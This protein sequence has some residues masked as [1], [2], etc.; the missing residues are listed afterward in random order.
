VG[1]Q[2]GIAPKPTRLHA[3]HSPRERLAQRER[4]RCARSKELRR[5]SP[6]HRAAQALAPREDGLASAQF[7]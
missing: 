1:Y 3:A 7:R 5:G 6:R 2:S 4:L